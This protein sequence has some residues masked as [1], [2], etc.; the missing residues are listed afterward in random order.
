MKWYCLED[1]EEYVRAPEVFEDLEV[2]LD[3][4]GCDAA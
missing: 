1:K 4:S 3:S 2:C